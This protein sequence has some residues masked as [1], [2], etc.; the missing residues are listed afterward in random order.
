MPQMVKLKLV[1]EIQI[2]TNLDS[3][4]PM[5]TRY[6][7]MNMYKMLN[8]KLPIIIMLLNIMCWNVRG[9]M[10]SAYPLSELLDTHKID[11]AMLCEHKLFY[12]STSFLD[13]IHCD[14]LSYYTVNTSVD[15]YSIARCGRAGT[16]ILYRKKYHR[17]FT[18]IENIKNDRILGLK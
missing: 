14:F 10:S 6:T 3:R 17:Q 1:T 11:I 8:T 16:A 4:V 12:R 9:I 18:I 7:F 13:S 2:P 5:H 15:P